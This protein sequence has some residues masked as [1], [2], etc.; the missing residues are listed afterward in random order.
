[1]KFLKKKFRSIVR[2]TTVKTA[3]FLQ[4]IFKEGKQRYREVF[5]DYNLP[6]EAAL[7]I[8]N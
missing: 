8:K 6:N 4:R 3:C 2:G 7:T 5:D 1:M